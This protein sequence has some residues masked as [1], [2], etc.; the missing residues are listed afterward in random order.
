MRKIPLGL[1]NRNKNIEDNDILK[2]P[3]ALGKVESSFNIHSYDNVGTFNGKKRCNSTAMPRN[4]SNISDL[5]RMMSNEANHSLLASNINTSKT[6]YEESLINKMKLDVTRRC[7][8]NQYLGYSGF[9]SRVPTPK[10]QNVDRFDFA[11]PNTTGVCAMNAAFADRKNSKQTGYHREG[12]LNLRYSKEL[13]RSSKSDLLRSEDVYHRNYIE[14]NMKPKEQRLLLKTCTFEE[15]KCTEPNTDVTYRAESITTSTPQS[16]KFIEEQASR[17]LLVLN[18]NIN[19]KISATKESTRKTSDERI[20]QSRSRS[21]GYSS[22]LNINI[23]NLI[24]LDFRKTLSRIAKKK[25]QESSLSSSKQNDLA[26]SLIRR[27]CLDHKS[28]DEFVF[29]SYIKNKTSDR[30]KPRMIS[31]EHKH[32]KGF[33]QI[34]I[35]KQPLKSKI[36]PS[37][38]FLK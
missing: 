24:N 16:N 33:R 32:N 26:F 19:S 1:M 17:D 30:R 29:D 3:V 20:S 35:F 36:I 23:E 8:M 15:T 5:L 4:N 28:S 27:N 22:N 38:I 13:A 10:F 12:S 11:K 6:H 34:G 2:K 18:Y 7:D 37:E 31:R 14:P 21:R 25:K 9:S